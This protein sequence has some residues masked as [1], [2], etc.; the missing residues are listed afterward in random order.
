METVTDMNVLY[1]AFRASMKS[2]AWKE[3]PQR[4]ETDFLSEL[5]ALHNELSDRTYQTLPGTEFTQHE[6][7][8]IRHIHGN[9]MRD[10]VVRHAVIKCWLLPCTRT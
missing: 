9:R 10:R 7:G 4:F 2:S 3:E 8:K 5:V 6:R 1:D